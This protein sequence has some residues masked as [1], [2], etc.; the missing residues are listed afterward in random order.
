M[1][2]RMRQ[3]MLANGR[4]STPL[5]TAWLALID[6]Y[7]SDNPSPDLVQAAMAEVHRLTPAA[8]LNSAKA[9]SV[10]LF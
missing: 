2:A 6:Q 7:L 3:T 1:L 4:E 10:N 5:K 8:S 9:T